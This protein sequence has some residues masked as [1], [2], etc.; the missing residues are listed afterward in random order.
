MSLPISLL[1]SSSEKEYITLGVKANIRADGRKR[2]DFRHFVL[3]TDTIPQAAGSARVHLGATDILVS[4][5]TDIGRPDLETPE[6]GNIHCS[7]DS[8]SGGLSG[9]DQE[10]RRREDK[11]AEMSTTLLAMIKDSGG[12]NRKSLSIVPGKHCWSI[13]V[14]VLILGE[15][16]NV[17]DAI[18]LATRAALQRTR[19]P[20][21]TVEEG[22][23]ATEI[24]LSDNPSLARAIDVSSLPISVTLSQIG[25]AF[26]VDATIP[27]EVCT[28]SSLL[29]AVNRDGEILYTKK[30][31]FGCLE[32]GFLADMLQTGQRI[33]L[34]I[35]SKLDGELSKSMQL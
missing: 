2:L 23:E 1:L 4:I 26:V 32:A 18:M 33:G 34:Q 35:I 27:E 17:M 7:V 20:G 30:Y 28:E 24:V 21:V 13:F 29:I 5:K 11:N 6:E 12:L 10:D 16:G 31:S 9:A 19:L 3:D 25:Q 14:D 8:S 15:D 22:G